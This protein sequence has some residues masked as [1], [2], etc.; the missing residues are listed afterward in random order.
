MKNQEDLGRMSQTE[1]EV[2]GEVWR[3]LPPVTVARLLEIFAARRG[4]KIS[5]LST[6]LD[7]LIGKGYLTKAMR[8]GVNYFTP[9]FTE[10]E[11][12]ER[13]TRAFLDAMYDGS[14]RNFVA[15]LADSGKLT[16]EEVAEM[17]A[18]FLAEAG[19]GQ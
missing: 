14:V 16:A 3:M 9:A 15:A 19:D 11:Y 4:W 18:W 13:E 7:R 17:K 12:R 10:G 1:L 2:M 8:A 5:T 6:I